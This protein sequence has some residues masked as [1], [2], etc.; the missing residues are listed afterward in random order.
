MPHRHRM[1]TIAVTV[2]WI[3]A[4]AATLVSAAVRS[5][6]ARPR[7]STITRSTQRPL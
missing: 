3:I 5:G 2:I 1:L 7:A 4:L 6:G